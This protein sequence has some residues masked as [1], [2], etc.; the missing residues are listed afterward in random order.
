MA[1]A[2]GQSYRDRQALEAKMF[3]VFEKTIVH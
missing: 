1:K 2:R 3:Y